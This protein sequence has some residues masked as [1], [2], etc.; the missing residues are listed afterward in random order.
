MDAGLAAIRAD[1]GKD[2]SDLTPKDLDHAAR[3][4]QRILRTDQAMLKNNKKVW[5]E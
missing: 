1:T 3:E 4:L 5:D 2:L